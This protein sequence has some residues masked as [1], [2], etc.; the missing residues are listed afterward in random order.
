MAYRTESFL[1]LGPHEFHRVVY[2][3]WGDPENERVLICV[4]GMTRNG[5]DF[6]YIA[7]ALSDHYRVVCP[8]L[9]GRG[10]SEWLKVKEDYDYPVYCADMSALL[11]R[12]GAESVDWLGT[13]MGGIIGVWMAAVGNTPIRKL[14]LNDVGPFISKAALQR[15]ATYVGSDPR[16]DSMQE[17]EQYVR[18]LN[19]QFGP[20][21][22]EQW[23]H[24][25]RYYTRRTADGDIG[26]NYDPDIA[27]VLR[28]PLDD[29]DLFPIWAGVSCPTLILRGM[30]SDV[31]LPETAERMVA[32]NP[33]AKLVQFPGIGHVPALMSDDQIGIVRDWLL[34][35]TEMPAG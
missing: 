33:H 8:D 7:D 28:K 12:L 32:E 5:R 16:F 19:E 15:I 22:D 25:T 29:V 10:E 27:H 23:A 30:D 20:L 14:V 31:L 2:Y 26:L 24:Q 13:S 11:A 1:S 21:S 35:G 9:V 3:E 6:D 34:A 4:H 18:E 17:A